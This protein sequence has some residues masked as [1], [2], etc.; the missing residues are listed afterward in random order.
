M[1]YFRFACILCL[2]AFISSSGFGQCTPPTLYEYRYVYPYRAWVGLSLPSGAYGEI[3][4][5]KAGE[6]FSGIHNTSSGFDGLF[7]FYN[8]DPDTDYTWRARAICNGG[9]VSAW[10]A[11]YSFTTPPACPPAPIAPL[12]SAITLNFP[13]T[14]HPNI[15]YIICGSESNYG[16][17]YVWGFKAPQSGLY[18]LKIVS[19][20]GNGYIGLGLSS[21]FHPECKGIYQQCLSINTPT[22]FFYDFSLS[23]GDSIYFGF[24]TYETVPNSRTFVI[25]LKDCPAPAALDVDTITDTTAWLRFS[26][27]LP[28]DVELAPEGTAFTGQP[29]FINIKSSAHLTGLMPG[30]TYKWQ[31][32]GNCQSFGVGPWLP[33]LTFETAG[34]CDSIPVL[35]CDTTYEFRFKPGI[36]RYYFEEYATDG[37]EILLRYRPERSDMLVVT[38]GRP[39]PYGEFLLAWRDSS[40]ADCNTG[41]WPD[42]QKYN[43]PSHTT[44]LGYAEAGHTYYLLFD[45]AGYDTLTVTLNIHCPDICP[46]PIQLTLLDTQQQQVTLNWKNNNLSDLFE[47]EVQMLTDTFTG[48][49]NYTGTGT[50]LAVSG[51]TA[52]KKYHWRI[53]NIC[54]GLPG[55]WSK[56]AVF[57]TLPDCYMATTIDCDEIVTVDSA[58]S[59][60]YI[61]P[62]FIHNADERYFLFTPPYDGHFTIAAT[63]TGSIPQHFAYSIK[64]AS[65]D[66]S[67]FG[68]KCLG[69]VYGAGELPTG[70]LTSGFTYRLAVERPNGGSASE[71]AQQFYIQC[72]QPCIVADSLYVANILPGQ[73]TLGWRKMGNEEHWDI[74]LVP[75]GLPFTGIPNF[76][77]D[78]IAIFLDNLQP[79]L[80]Y[81]WR[82]RNDC[83]SYGLTDWSQPFSFTLPP[84]CQPIECGETKTL[85]FV[86]GT[87]YF[88]PNDIC[89]GG[90]P[91]GQDALVTFTI[92]S[93]NAKRYLYFPPG[94]NADRFSF[95]VRNSG[96]ANCASTGIGWTCIGNS[97]IATV[98]T[99]PNLTPGS[100]H[101]LIKKLLPD[102]TDTVTFRFDCDLLCKTPV[103]L[104]TEILGFQNVTAK[105]Q[106]SVGPWTYEVE[107]S[108]LSGTFVTNKILGSS[109][110]SVN[111]LAG[112]SLIPD[113]VYQWRV[114]RLCDTGDA[115]LWS[116]YHNFKAPFDCAGVPALNCY[117]PV[118]DT[119]NAQSSYTMLNAC[120]TWT[121]GQYSIYKIQLPFGTPDT[122]A[123][124]ILNASGAPFTYTLSS[125]TQISCAQEPRPWPFCQTASG[126]DFLLLGALTPGKTYYLQIFCTDS[127]GGAQTFQLVCACKAPQSGEGSLQASGDAKLNWSTSPGAANWDVEI[128]PKDSTFSG[129]PTHAADQMPLLVNGLDINIDYKFR[130]R[131]ACNSGWTGNWSATFPVYRLSDC[132]H[133]AVLTCD[134]IIDLYVEGGTGNFD[135]NLCGMAN[136]GKEAYFIIEPTLSGNYTASIVSKTGGAQLFFGYMAQCADTS[137]ATCAIP[138]SY[139]SHETL[140]LPS[141]APFMFYADNLNLQSGIYGLQLGCPD[142]QQPF[143][144]EPFGGALPPIFN[145]SAITLAIND[146]CRVF[147]NHL[148]TAGTDDPDPTLP[149]GNWYDGT[150]HS[151]WFKFV[152][153][154]GGTVQVTVESHAEYPM[155]PQV[156]LLQIDSINFPWS[157]QV[158]A[159]G[160]DQPGPLPQNALLNYSGLIPGQSYYLM[161]D[162]ANGS[163]GRFCLR[164]SD[165]PLLSLV[166]GVC[167]TFVQ[168]APVAQNAETWRNL[169]ASNSLHING[170]LL[171]AIKTTEDLGAITIQSEI[172]S[173]PPV[174]PSGQKIL[175]RYFNIEPENAPLAPVTVRLFFTP[176]DLATFNLTPPVTIATPFQLGVTHYDGNDEDCDPANNALTAG[177][178]GVQTAA[179]TLTGQNGL[180]YLETVVDGFSELGAAIN[181][182]VSTQEPTTDVA[183]S[184]FPN[185]VS[186]VLEIVLQSNAPAAIRLSLINLTGQLVWSEDW[187]VP[188]G[189]FRHNLMMNNLPSGI[190][191]LY[192]Q[193][194]GRIGKRV[195]VVKI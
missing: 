10:S 127:L 29:T 54:A 158:L 109:S 107:I 163:E 152:A 110:S 114:R 45:H 182:A 149:P 63:A 156:A 134:Q 44:P 124:Q 106:G 117:Q 16:G 135:Q 159:T 143:N 33:G 128:V 5:V 15:G 160:E 38:A 131:T 153:P 20:T 64:A 129:F 23:A 36:G 144:D 43:N 121:T 97:S 14:Q 41:S 168:S 75:Q 104:K 112:T 74:E 174:L 165:E 60:N 133:P 157:F 139:G 61:D 32:R 100:Y 177:G 51:L 24:H 113:Q 4:I 179:A 7:F 132:L 145:F 81:Q 155:D 116:P 52:L 65:L 115:S 98:M 17:S 47:V 67:A 2:L 140:Y 186:D 12:D 91:T 95:Y 111:L 130:V 147:T 58:P 80:G 37:R 101:L 119:F 53:R 170:P 181:P 118:S 103:D 192:L 167:E 126:Q 30:T 123:L 161:V 141:D 8:L 39:S 72:P 92:D 94:S 193:Q 31:L 171:A 22:D 35:R 70:F 150:E 18:R 78:S 27:D 137:S 176:E 57:T 26:P 71:Y 55:T 6:P 154:P 184:I 105:W 194:E 9:G 42:Y 3:E 89:N 66:C 125:G 19:A 25:Q 189:S 162:G 146:D 34:D 69:L 138:L 62:C 87:G 102:S 180:F 68:W 164:V 183:L 49:P 172:L 169:Y 40:V 84:V 83:G 86:E 96:G 191:Q 48:I 88:T 108:T 90:L 79:G 99:I 82:V 166:E 142:N 190:Y 188:I 77:S 73:A 195:A 11:V 178:L 136:P 50:E 56:P 1:L 46:A 28:V 120:G 59:G 21:G 93:I 13:T 122:F 185:P 76:T 175:P 148:A 187:H 173:D 85:T 151:V